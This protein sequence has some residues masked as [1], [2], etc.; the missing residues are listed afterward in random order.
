MKTS[1]NTVLY[2]AAGAFAVLIAAWIALFYIA[3]RN[4]VIP[5]PVSNQ[6]IR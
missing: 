3:S 6:S 2:W 4:R 1:R 5:V